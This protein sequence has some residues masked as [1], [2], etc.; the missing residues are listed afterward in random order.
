MVIPATTTTDSN[1]SGD[2]DTSNDDSTTSTVSNRITQTL[3]RITTNVRRHYFEEGYIPGTT[4]VA[5]I[6]LYFLALFGV[7]AFF[8]FAFDPLVHI[9]FAAAILSF[10]IGVV[11][12]LTLWVAGIVYRN[13]FINPAIFTVKLGIGV[14]S[15]CIVGGF[16]LYGW[17]IPLVLGIAA[18]T[19]LPPFAA[20]VIAPFAIVIAVAFAFAWYSKGM[21]KIEGI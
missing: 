10:V 16:L 3:S 13:G 6:G 7:L 15:M 5:Q 1:M 9:F 19:Q 8:T 17:V 11:A 18:Y 14:T 12:H 21:S 2:T 4:P 20:D